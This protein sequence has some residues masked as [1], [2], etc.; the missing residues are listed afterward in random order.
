MERQAHQRDD[1]LMMHSGVDDGL[2]GPDQVPDIVHVV[3][4]AIPVVPAAAISR[5]GGRAPPATAS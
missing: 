3:E 4:V 1:D 5:P 2:A